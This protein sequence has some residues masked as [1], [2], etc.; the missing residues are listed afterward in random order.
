[1]CPQRKTL[2][3]SNYQTRKA[4]MLYFIYSRRKIRNDLGVKSKLKRAFNYKSDGH[5][6]HDLHTLIDLE[7]IEEKESFFVITK[8][9]R[10][11]FQLLETLK[12][13]AIIIAFYGIY[14]FAWNLL[15]Y[16]NLPLNYQSPYYSIAL[17]FLAIA[18]L[19]YYS[20]RSFRPLPPDPSEEI[21]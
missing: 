16:S 13:T 14:I 6:Y 19:I 9:G 3:K 1:M 11:E 20:F 10:G 12:V 18:L 5:L 21:K 8:K 15:F 17:T 7:L 4:R 2:I